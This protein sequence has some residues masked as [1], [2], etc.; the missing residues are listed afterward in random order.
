MLR[1]FI[2]LKR[3]RWLADDVFVYL[4]FL[5]SFVLIFNFPD[6]KYIWSRVIILSSLYLLFFK[7]DLWS[8]E[9]KDKI[10]ILFFYLSFG[11]YLFF[12]Q[13]HNDGNSDFPR[14]VFYIFLFFLVLPSALINFQVLKYILILGSSLSGMV[15]IYEFIILDAERVGFYVLNPIPISFYAGLIFIL[16]A[17]F[18]L[19]S[20]K[21]DSLL[22]YSSSVAS[23]LSLTTIFLTQTR[24]TWLALGVVFLIYASYAFFRDSRKDKLLLFSFFIAFSITGLSLSSVKD[25]VS[26]AYHQ[27]LD[28]KND[29]YNSSTGIRIKLWESGLDIAR[30]GKIL[31]LNRTDVQ[32]ITHAKIDSLEYP[33]FIKPF[34]I[35]PNPNFHNQYIQMLVDSGVI[36]LFF[37]IV[38]IFLPILVTVI[39]S[40]A[41]I[42]PISF[43][44]VTF[45][46]V[47]LF[48]DS[49]FMYNHT[50]IL[51]GFI[52]LL[53][54]YTS[55][56]YYE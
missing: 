52:T 17:W 46:L 28:Y 10:L 8:V 49:L 20:Y 31:G 39:S 26:D 44:I 54:Y 30:E 47:C 33:I 6:S 1:F 18:V 7:F 25:R 32:H 22:F 4:P 41:R 51:Y 12:M 55:C 40:R 16:N 29:N 21:K 5:I 15:S 14:S 42:V 43:L 50:V 53:I 23:I 11:L 19:T 3:F 38:F 27:I 45:S 2:N 48:F 56:G 13:H 35:H 9:I 34:L 37:L 24:A 36:G